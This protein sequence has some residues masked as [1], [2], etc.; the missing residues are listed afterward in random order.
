MNPAGRV[1]LIRHGR[2]DQG[3]RPIMLG[4]TDL[5]LSDQG[6]DQIAALAAGLAGADIKAIYASPLLR[7]R[8]SAE[9][10]AQAW[11]LTVRIEPDWREIDLGDWDGLPHELIRERFPDEYAARGRDLADYRPP[12]GESFRD[13]ADRVTAAFA[14]LTKNLTGSIALVGHAGVQ[15]VLLCHILGLPLQNQFRLVM[16][17]GGWSRLDPGP[18]SGIRLSA[19]NRF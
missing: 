2:V 3:D 5:A 18:G 7:C 6:R 19:L 12:G 16:E 15:R 9:I 14:R 8:Q 11:G 4:Q 10:L 1:Y 17:P 13:L